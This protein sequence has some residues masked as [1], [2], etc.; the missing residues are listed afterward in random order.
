VNFEQL[1][2]MALVYALLRVGQ[3]IGSIARG[4]N[5]ACVDVLF[6]NWVVGHCLW[7]AHGRVS[8]LPSV[9]VIE[10]LTAVWL[11]AMVGSA[12]SRR[13]ACFSLGAML[14]GMTIYLMGDPAPPWK[15]M[16]MNAVAWGQMAALV[17]GVWGDGLGKAVGRAVRDRGRRNRAVADAPHSGRE[18]G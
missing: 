6:I 3:P 1:V 14:A 13:L 8:H 11:V 12:L 7:M 4:R 15:T 17:W 5:V 9:I 16:A 2:Y 18:Q 10:F